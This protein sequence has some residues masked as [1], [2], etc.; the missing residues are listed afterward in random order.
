M[1]AGGVA[2][3]QTPHDRK[4]GKWIFYSKNLKTGKTLRE[5]ME[6][7]V[8]FIDKKFKTNFVKARRYRN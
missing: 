7:L 2:T 4:T 1:D 6:N 5:E 3:L 8:K